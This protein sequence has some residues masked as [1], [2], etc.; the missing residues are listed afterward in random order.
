[1]K[2]IIAIFF[3]LFSFS[4]YSND[5]DELI[6][7]ANNGDAEAQYNLGNIYYYGKSTITDYEK[8][9]NYYKLS[10]EQGNLYAQHNL[11]TMYYFGTGVPK[12]LSI[13]KEWFKKSCDQKFVIA[14]GYYKKLNKLN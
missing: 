6:K 10:A 4:A 3:I 7:K 1:M 14:C 9:I 12:N 11:G 5:I 13:A 2:K 8:A